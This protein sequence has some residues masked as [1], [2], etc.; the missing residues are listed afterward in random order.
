[1]RRERGSKS[2]SEKGRRA[3]IPP[4]LVLSNLFFNLKSLW[5][6]NYPKA[7]GRVLVIREPFKQLHLIASLGIPSGWPLDSLLSLL[8][9]WSFIPPIR[10]PII[11]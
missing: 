7:L 6:P 4:A 9:F 2:P 8:S 5:A 3:L 11:R 1:M 10:S